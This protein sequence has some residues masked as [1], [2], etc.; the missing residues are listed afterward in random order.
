[1]DLQQITETRL[2]WVKKTDS[3]D[4]GYHKH[5][6]TLNELLKARRMDQI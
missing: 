5:E 1:M 2:Y 6:T 4:S 3:K